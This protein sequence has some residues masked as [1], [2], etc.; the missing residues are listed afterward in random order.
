MYESFNCKLTC[1]SFENQVHVCI[2]F[3]VKSDNYAFAGAGTTF[4]TFS[5]GHF[6]YFFVQFCSVLNN[7]AY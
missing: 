2:V 1:V 7:S 5:G 6:V 4:T 3:T